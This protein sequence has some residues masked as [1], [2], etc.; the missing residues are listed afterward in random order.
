M[1]ISQHVHGP[2]QT[3]DSAASCREQFECLRA[4]SCARLWGLCRPMTPD[5]LPTGAS[6]T[7]SGAN[8]GGWGATP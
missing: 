8:Q 4:V 7:C 3:D 1:P 6:S 5:R 2:R